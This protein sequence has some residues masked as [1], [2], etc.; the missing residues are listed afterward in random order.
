MSKHVK[1]IARLLSKPTDF[2]WSE[3]IVVM[4]AFGYELKTNGGSARKFAK[5]EAVF[6]IHEPHPY[7]L[8]KAYQVRA[9]IAFL[10]QEGDI[11]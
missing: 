9:V 11:Q 4:E 1:L 8:L 7:K 10:K 3:L 6:F 2:N 5:P